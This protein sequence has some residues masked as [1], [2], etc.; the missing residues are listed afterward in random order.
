ML[1]LLVW[2]DELIGQVPQVP[3]HEQEDLPFFLF[4]ICVAI[5][6]MTIT[7]IIA[8]IIIVGKFIFTS[9]LFSRNR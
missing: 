3:P 7:A 6:A 9:S 4:R 8:V 2:H 1:L 5:I